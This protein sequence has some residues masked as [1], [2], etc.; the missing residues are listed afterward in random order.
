MNNVFTDYP[1]VTWKQNWPL[2]ADE[3][4]PSFYTGLN[5]G[6]ILV[7]DSICSLQLI[8][9]GLP[10]T[11][12][13]LHNGLSIHCKKNKDRSR[14]EVI[15]PEPG[16]LLGRIANL[17][18]PI[19]QAEVR[20]PSCNGLSLYQEKGKR[21]LLLSDSNRFVLLCTDLPEH[22]AIAKAEELL[23]ENIAELLEEESQ[24]R[25]SDT[26]LLSINTRHNPAVVLACESLRRRLRSRNAALPGTWSLADG[27]EHE[28]FSLNELYPLTRAWCIIDPSIARKLVRTALALQRS[29]GGFPSWITAQGAVASIA[30]WPLIIQSFELAW[31]TTEDEA[32]LKKQ[33]PAL[34]K[35]LQWA[36]RRFDPHRDGVP[37]WQSENEI[38]VP[39]SYELDKATPELTTFLLAEIDALL[40]LS[41][42]VGTPE[43][44]LITLRE[45][46]SQLS[47]TLTTIFWNPEQ[48]SFSNAWKNG[49]YLHEPSFASFMPL[50]WSA[51]EPSFKDAILNNFEETHGFPG[52][53]NPASWKH[54][55][56]DDTKHLPA[57][58]QFLAFEALHHCSARKSLQ[59]LFINRVR[60]GYAGWFERENIEAAR[61]IN[62]QQQTAA[63]AYA[64]GPITAALILSVQKQFQ[65]QA[66]SHAPVLKKL[67]YGLHRI[68]AN[69]QDLKI[70]V[71]FGIAMLLTHL[72]YNLP[73][74]QAVREAQLAEAALNYKEGNLTEAM[75]IC[76]EWPDEPLCKF[77]QANLLLLTE[78]FEDAESMYRDVLHAETESPS[79]LFGYALSLQLSGQ[80]DQAIKRYNDFLDIYENTLLQAGNPRLIDRTHELLRLA[81]EGFSKPPR[82]KELLTMPLMDDLG[83]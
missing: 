15:C 19:L 56:L 46:R 10:C 47:Q 6:N 11:T 7:S 18:D 27:F 41:E 20:I 43:D 22:S 45:Q 38:L 66:S 74:R 14:I 21:T 48:K 2:S 72:V 40:R 4:E 13:L 44:S 82:W 81:E 75:R 71:I 5:P 61:L 64:M 37:S 51:L 16:V 42:E 35:Y 49:H 68:K 12:R 73:K 78:N 28:T 24:C 70:I 63:P 52:G 62:H 31:R 80:L 50:F 36:L 25:K 67:R 34:R 32:A 65:T 33:L 76:R 58:H 29:D 54:E 23:E 3:Q 26:A 69:T 83:L 60:E 59:N 30:P 53:H 55:Q 39:D 57:I 79:A 8:A 1:P 9:P 17:P 77:L